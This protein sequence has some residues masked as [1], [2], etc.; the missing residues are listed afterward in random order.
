MRALTGHIGGIIS[1]SM[2]AD[3]LLVSGG[4]EG[5]ARVWDLS[6]GVSKFVLEGH[7]NGGWWCVDAS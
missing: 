6:T 2:T 1:L 5:H 4:W 7:E 3:G